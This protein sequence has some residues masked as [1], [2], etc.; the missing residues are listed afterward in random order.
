MWEQIRQKSPIFPRSSTEA[1]LK[2]WLHQIGRR[3]VPVN[4]TAECAAYTLECANYGPM[5]I[6]L[7]ILWK[8]RRAT[9]RCRRFLSPTMSPLLSPTL[10]PTMAPSISPPPFADDVAAA[11]ADAVADVVDDDIIA[12]AFTLSSISLI[13]RIIS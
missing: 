4:K 9:R 7:R 6:P 10:S 1:L 5:N 12:D 8:P 3:N 2:Q 13:S 11:F